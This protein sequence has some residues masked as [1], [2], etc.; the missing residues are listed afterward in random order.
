MPTYCVRTPPV[1]SRRRRGTEVRTFSGVLEADR[2]LLLTGR[3]G[4]RFSRRTSGVRSIRGGA[5]SGRTLGTRLQ[6]RRNGFRLGAA[7]ARATA[8]ASGTS[9]LSTTL[10]TTLASALSTTISTL[11]T[12]ISAT[13]ATLTANSGFRAP[14]ARERVTLLLVVTRTGR[15][16]TA[17]FVDRVGD[18]FRNQLH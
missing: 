2:V 10:S 9:T 17:R 3:I 12:A 4:S 6:A 14:L 13:A 7:T 15:R 18:D 8:V 16:F 5:L 11:A 1:L